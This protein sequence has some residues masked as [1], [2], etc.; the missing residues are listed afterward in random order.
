MK[1]AHMLTLTARGI[2]RAD[3]RHLRAEVRRAWSLVSEVQ[4]AALRRRV[5]KCAVVN[6]VGHGVRSDAKLGAG[7]L[8]GGKR[9]RKSIGD[10]VL[11]ERR[12]EGLSDT[13]NKRIPL[14]V[15]RSEAV[16]VDVAVSRSKAK[17]LPSLALSHGSKGAKP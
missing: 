9:Q 5:E 11:D 16:R 7:S 10:A 12:H 6:V 2:S 14:G 8:D 13:S 1:P 3:L 15:A 4:K 17:G